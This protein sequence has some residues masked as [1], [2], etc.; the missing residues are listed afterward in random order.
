[1]TGGG[2]GDV[3]TSR[4]S[5]LPAIGTGAGGGDGSAGAGVLGGDGTWASS[6]LVLRK[7][8]GYLSLHLSPLDALP[9]PRASRIS[10]RPCWA[11]ARRRGGMGH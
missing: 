8:Q 5:N 10:P 3:R 9:F 1:M 4:S 11:Q 7:V 6:N 2:G